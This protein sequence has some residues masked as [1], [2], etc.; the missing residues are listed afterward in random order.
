M[1]PVRLLAAGHQLHA[2]LLLVHCQLICVHMQTHH[3]LGLLQVHTAAMTQVH[4]WALMHQMWRGCK[5]RE[6][7]IQM[8]TL[9]PIP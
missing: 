6:K 8:V 1:A 5:N 2:S 4:D 9:K 3:R 7:V